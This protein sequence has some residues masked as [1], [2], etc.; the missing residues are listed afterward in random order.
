M[1]F[2]NLTSYGVQ[3]GAKFGFTLAVLY[4]LFVSY[5]TSGY[6]FTGFFLSL[7]YLGF[8]GIF[9]AAILGA[10]IGG[11]IG[12]VVKTGNLFFEQQGSAV[13]IIF[14]LGAG[15]T[16]PTLVCIWLFKWAFSSSLY[17]PPA[18]ICIAAGGWVAAILYRLDDKEGLVP[19]KGYNSYFGD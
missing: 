3:I 12:F 13:R 2:M 19:Y 7:A 16:I 4:T 8:M 18:Y 9:P 10:L 6:S 14:G 1:S 15:F 11:L 17:L 5:L